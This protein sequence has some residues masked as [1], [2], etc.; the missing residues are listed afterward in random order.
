MDVIKSE[1]STKDKL[2]NS[3]LNFF[4]TK[5]YD[6]TTVDEIAEAIGMKGPIIYNYFSGKEDILNVL[7]HAFTAEYESNMR[8]GKNALVWIH[9]GAELKEFTMHQVNYTINDEHVTKYRRLGFINQFRNE[10]M[11]QTAT[12]FQF[13]NIVNLFERVFSYMQQNDAIGDVD[14]R[15][16]SLE[17]TSPTSLLI[18]LV[19]REPKRKDEAIQLIEKHVD[20]FI[21]THCKK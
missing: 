10:E 15:L 2:L 6:A 9:N 12:Q 19:D 17:Y 8:L 18:Q 20:F 13:D 16:L 7:N 4:S 11:A 1:L 5:G 14:P 3:A 21:A